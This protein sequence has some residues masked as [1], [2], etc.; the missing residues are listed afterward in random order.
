MPS[1]ASP[2][3]SV[4]DSTPD[5]L[6]LAIFGRLARVHHPAG[7][8]H[9]AVANEAEF[10]AR[11]G[12]L[13]HFVVHAHAGGKRLR[14]AVQ[15]EIRV[16]SAWVPKPRSKTCPPMVSGWPSTDLFFCGWPQ[17][18]VA[19]RNPVCPARPFRRKRGGAERGQG[20]GQSQGG[21][22]LHGLILPRKTP[23]SSS[24]APIF[25]YG[26]VRP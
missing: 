4:S 1:P 12:I 20:E 22:R 25:C 2:T 19:E 16:L 21:V 5:K 8:Q 24:P 26:S 13:V 17:P 9:L 3:F 18:C 14:A 15:I 7:P 23:A 10:H 11:G 6:H